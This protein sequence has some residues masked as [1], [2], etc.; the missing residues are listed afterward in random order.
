MTK[1]LTIK[2]AKFIKAKA[3]GKTGV[4]SALDAYDT[5]DYNTA[6]VIANENLQKPIIQE[7]LQ[8]ALL[9]HHIDLDSALLPISKSLRGK[10]VVEVEGDFIETEQDDLDL[11]LKA[12]DRALKL[13]GVTGAIAG[14]QTAFINVIS[15]DRDKYKL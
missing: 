15:I 5:K 14:N 3:S 7:A 12:S 1:R 4:Q 8:K 10:H 9:K 11:Q 6:N 13:L 2:Q